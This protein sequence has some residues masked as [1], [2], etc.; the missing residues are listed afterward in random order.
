MEV[1][2]TR[3]MM[4]FDVLRQ[5]G[6]PNPLFIHDKLMKQDD[7]DKKMREVSKDQANLPSSQGIPVGKVLYKNFENLFYLQHEVK[8][9]FFN[10]PT[11]SKYIEADEIFRKMVKIKLLEAELWE[12]LIDLI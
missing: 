7:Y 4:K 1:S 3:F 9:L 12:N 8:H 5:K 11:F 2:I 6:L 10:K